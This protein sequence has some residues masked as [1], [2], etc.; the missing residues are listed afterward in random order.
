[1]ERR[2]DDFG[3][4]LAN[5]E[6]KECHMSYVPSNLSRLDSNSQFDQRIQ[7]HNVAIRCAKWA[8]DVNNCQYQRVGSDYVQQPT[9]RHPLQESVKIPSEDDPW[10]ECQS[11]DTAF[12]AQ[13][14]RSL[15]RQQCKQ[16][17]LQHCPHSQIQLKCTVF[18]GHS[19]VDVDPSMLRNSQHCI[20]SDVDISLSAV[21][22]DLNDS[23]IPVLSQLKMLLASEDVESIEDVDRAT[24]YLKLEQMR[25]TDSS[26]PHGADESNESYNI[27]EFQ[28]VV[29]LSG[30]ELES[31]SNWKGLPTCSAGMEYVSCQRTHKQNSGLECSSSSFSTDPYYR[32]EGSKM[33]HACDREQKW[34]VDTHGEASRYSTQGI[35][36]VSL[37]SQVDDLDSLYT[38][39]T[40]FCTNQFL[41][42]PTNI[43]A[44]LLPGSVQ[45][46]VKNMSHKG[47]QQQDYQE[48]Y[49]ADLPVLTSRV[50]VTDVEYNGSDDVI[51]KKLQSSTLPTGRSDPMLIYMSSG[52]KYTSTAILGNSDAHYVSGISSCNT[53]KRNHQTCDELSSL[54][55]Q[56]TVSGMA[57]SA[58]DANK[59]NATSPYIQLPQTQSSCFSSSV[60]QG[61][62]A[63]TQQSIVT[64]SHYDDSSS[65]SSHSAEILMH[66][67]V[68]KHLGVS[69]MQG[70]TQ[71]PNETDSVR[72]EGQVTAFSLKSNSAAEEDKLV[73]SV[74][75][76]TLPECDASIS[77]ELEP[78]Y[79][80][81]VDSLHAQGTALVENNAASEDEE[82]T[83]FDLDDDNLQ[84]SLSMPNTHAHVPRNKSDY[85]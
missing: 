26:Q 29:G 82:A 18:G 60:K 48:T 84:C 17:H 7:N 23:H 45:S 36:M 32:L 44:E 34:P 10:S 52:S 51:E 14:T 27:A 25:S 85:V 22:V 2:R 72:S 79:Y 83:E 76:L 11:A 38:E 47:G 63:E 12:V 56:S 9:W 59:M 43:S 42:D 4:S 73:I 54:A 3:Q 19:V 58:S 6:N 41:P 13:S 50:D 77:R 8:Q 5:H 37:E 53:I 70:S 39:S 80:I 78:S 1:M 61:R 64:V 49:T 69:L 62:L 55:A 66:L 15:L 21:S 75:T 65:V 24:D 71:Q 35:P 40:D 31:K 30:L 67:D 20:D 33:F 81:S 57:M 16:S 46:S 68:D 28:S 74:G